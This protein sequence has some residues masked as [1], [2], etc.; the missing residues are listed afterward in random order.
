LSKQISVFIPRKK[1]VGIESI[2]HSEDEGQG[3]LSFFAE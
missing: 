2:L 3:N 1:T